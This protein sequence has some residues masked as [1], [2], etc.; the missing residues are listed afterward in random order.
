MKKT[1]ICLFALCAYGISY[2][3]TFDDVILNKKRYVDCQ[4]VT[5]NAPELIRS[6][7]EKNQIDSL[8]SFLDYWQ[9]KCGDLEYIQSLRIVLDIK[10]ANFDAAIIDRNFFNSLIF[11]KE[12][13]AYIRKANYEYG[14][15]QKNLQ[16][17]TR[18]IASSIQQ[19]Y[20][21][22]EELLQDF[23]TADT[24]SFSKIKNASPKES[25]L[26]QQYDQ[27][28]KETLSQ[29]E[30]HI[31]GFVGYYHPFGKLDVFGPHPSI[32]M[33]LGVRQ[34]RQ[35]LDLVFDVRFGRSKE[36]YE[37]IYQGDLV[38][39]DRWTSVYCGLE[40]TYD[41]IVRKN[42]RLGFSPGIAYNGITAVPTNDENDNE[43]KIL[44]GFDVNGGL[45]MKYA[46]GKKGAYAG[47]QA[48]YHWVDHRNPGGT[49][50]YGNYLSLRLIFGSIFSYDRDYNLRRL[51][52]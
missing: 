6:M 2:A 8:Y 17:E 15:L 51:D 32:G 34:L 39:D 4:D 28:L 20:S 13:V 50:L 16:K 5:F 46:L 18:E 52:Y 45:A 37:F 35:T 1:L 21:V 7:R 11:Y 36:N 43:S 26:R 41:F 22:D 29:P 25:K 27:Y 42:F 3:Q 49:E 23:Y 19:S 44:R 48:R 47:L 30:M 33:V 38:E 9:N 40:Y 12:N 10:T 14:Q 31:A 24:A